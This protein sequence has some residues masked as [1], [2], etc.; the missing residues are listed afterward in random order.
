[1]GIETFMN[2]GLDYSLIL[3]HDTTFASWPLSDFLPIPVELTSI[4]YSIVQT[5]RLRLNVNVGKTTLT[6]LSILDI[7]LG[8]LLTVLFNQNK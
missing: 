7:T 2:E 1:M 6:T 8:P 4:A 3:Q 5:Y